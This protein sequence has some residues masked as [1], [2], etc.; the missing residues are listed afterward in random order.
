MSGGARYAFDPLNPPIGHRIE[1]KPLTVDEIHDLLNTPVAGRKDD[2]GKDD[3][4]LIPWDGLAPVMRVLMF[5]M[6]KYDRD[7]WRKVPDSTVRYTKALLRHLVAHLSGEEKDEETG[8]SHLAHA[9]CCL[10]FLLGK[11]ASP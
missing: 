10:L 6:R 2:K 9:A 7:N 1:P 11:R 5:G 4:T 3:W 8:E